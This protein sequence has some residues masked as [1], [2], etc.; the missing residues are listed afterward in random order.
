MDNSNLDNDNQI[1]PVEEN[2]E[3]TVEKVMTWLDKLIV[4]LS[5]FKICIKSS[6]TQDIDTNYDEFIN[7]SPKDKT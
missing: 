7:H 6:N 5:A 2:T 3:I 4:C 1:K